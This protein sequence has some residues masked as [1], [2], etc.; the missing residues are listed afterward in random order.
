MPVSVFKLAGT[1]L[2]IMLIAS[3][4]Y[5]AFRFMHN[6]N[7]VYWNGMTIPYTCIILCMAVVFAWLLIAN[8]VFVGHRL[9]FLTS[10]D[11]G[12]TA[13]TL[14]TILGLTFLLISMLGAASSFS[15][16]LA[17]QNACAH[18]PQIQ[19]VRTWYAAAQALRATPAC[20]QMYSIE[21]CVGFSDLAAKQEEYMYVKNME[22]SFRCQGFCGAA[23]DL[24]A[25]AAAVP[26]VGNA[27]ASAAAGNAS[28]T[29]A[30]GNASAP[31]AAGN[32][33]SA[34]NA[35][36]LLQLDRELI[37]GR[38]RSSLVSAFLGREMEM[39]QV[40][41]RSPSMFTA[42]K[43]FP[44]TL[45][46]DANFDKVSC[47]GAAAQDLLLVSMHITH[48]LWWQ[49]IVLVASSVV[50]GFTDWISLLKYK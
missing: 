16:E 42:G 24:A 6:F 19:P 45:F 14:A 3:P 47:N 36:S 12:M 25:A 18:D 27:S 40:P 22:E 10:H 41:R 44:P 23:G 20:K 35:T 9:E 37:E 34:G 13:A 49:G 15:T 5:E 4:I 31:P 11:L 50:I 39:E 8:L 17:L 28:G 21:D 43:T 48:E 33:S 46:S 2:V 26:V 30:A 29:P 38:K 1:F 7:Y 32:T